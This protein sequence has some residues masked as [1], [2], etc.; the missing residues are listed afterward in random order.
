M[1]RRLAPKIPSQALGLVWDST[2][3]VR[4]GQ[5]LCLPLPWKRWTAGHRFA[6]SNGSKWENH[7]NFPRIFRREWVSKGSKLWIRPVAAG[8]AAPANNLPGSNKG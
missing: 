8:G 1:L 2:S 4:W 3:S 7:P 6:K 5:S